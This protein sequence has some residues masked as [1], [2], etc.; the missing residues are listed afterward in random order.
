MPPPS[1]SPERAKVAKFY[2]ARSK[3][4]PP[5]P[6]QTFAL[7]F[8]IP[9]GRQ[10]FIHRLAVMRGGVAEVIAPDQLV[11][12]VQ[13][14]VV[15]G[16]VMRRAVLARRENSPPDCFLIL[17]APTGINV[18]PEPFMKKPDHLTG[19]DTWSGSQDCSRNP[20]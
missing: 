3:T 9:A 4:I 10:Q 5:L 11:F 19:C 1:L 2:S 20:A 17:L 6:W 16:A 18:F 13:I 8:S 12:S 7:P 14:E 15:H